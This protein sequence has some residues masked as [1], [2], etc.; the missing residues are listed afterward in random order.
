M[1]QTI[2]FDLDGTLTDSGPGIVKGVSYSLK[3]FGIDETRQEKLRKFIGPPLLD[4]YQMFYGFDQKKA[5]EAVKY[6]REYYAQTGLYE[7][8][9]YPGI[10][11]LLSELKENGRQLAVATSKPEVFAKKILEKYG[12]AQYFDVIVGGHL[13]G[14]RTKKEEVIRDALQE[15][16][17]IFLEKN[18]NK[19]EKDWDALKKVM[20]GDRFYD[21]SGA[22]ENRIDIILVE[23]G[24]GEKEELEREGAIAIAK[25]V[26]DLRKL[27]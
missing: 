19:R 13:D 20:I 12:L 5:K 17:K 14:S 24:Y 2:L 9:I 16:R 11:Q 18:K 22:R 3:K 15:C 4:S 23:Y 1:Y 6:Y 25:T 26:G 27:L 7:N 21:A 8:N 10:E